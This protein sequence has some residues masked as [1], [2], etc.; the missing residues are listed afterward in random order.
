MNQKAKALLGGVFTA[1]LSFGALA[2]SVN[3]NYQALDIMNG[4]YQVAETKLNT[5]IEADPNDAF[6][7]LNLA[8]I[9]DRTGRSHEARDLYR[10]VMQMRDN[11]YAK[12]ANRRVVPVKSI[13]SNALESLDQR[14]R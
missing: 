8:A 14:H 2:D 12:L 7:L 3:R 1:A 13:A 5:R 6:A 9:Y 10:R 4:D 11:P